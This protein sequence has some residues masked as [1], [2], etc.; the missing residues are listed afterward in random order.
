M[1]PPPPPPR[2]TGLHPA[3]PEPLCPGETVKFEASTSPTDATVTW[4]IAVNGE[5]PQIIQGDENTLRISGFSGQTI[6]VTASIPNSNSLSATARWKDAELKLDVPPGPNNGRY[7]ITDEPRMPV[8]TATAVGGG[9][10]EWEVT[11]AFTASDCPPFGPHDLRTLFRASRT[12]GNQV[13]TDFFG[14]V[15]RGGGISFHAKGVVNGCPVSAFGGAGL[16]GTNPQRTAIQKAIEDAGIDPKELAHTLGRIACKESGQRQFDAPP[17]GGTGYCPLFGPGGTVGIMQLPKPTDDEIW[18]WTANLATGIDKFKKSIKN[19]QAYL[20]ALHRSEKFGRL[21]KNFNEKRQQQGL[22]PIDIKCEFNLEQLEK[23]VIRGYYDGWVGADGFGLKLHEYKV[24][25][26]LIDGKEVLV[27]T[28][29]NEQTLQGKVVWQRVPVADRPAGSRQDYVEEVLAF[30]FDCTANTAQCNLTGIT[31]SAATLFIDKPDGFTKSTEF[32]AEGTGLA[33]VR[34]RAPGGTPATGT[35]PTFTTKWRKFGQKTVKATCGG[36]TKTATVSV[37]QVEIQINETSSTKDD[38]VQLKSEHPPHSFKVPC[39]ARLRGATDPLDIVLTSHNDRLGFVVGLGDPTPTKALRLPKTGD[40]KFEITGE[41]AS[42]VI[43]D[44]KIQVKLGTAT[45][46]IV[47]EQNVTVFSFDEAKIELTRG[48][49]YIFASG[50]FIPNGIA[51]S[52]K[53]KARL[54]PE[55]LDCNA[56]QIKKL[57]VAIMQ[58]ESALSVRIELGSPKFV[59]KPHVHVPQQEIEVAK[60]VLINVFFKTLPPINDANKGA[61]PPLYASDGAA[62]KR[63]TGCRGAGF[64]ASN[65]SP[66]VETSPYA[67]PLSLPGVGEV[68]WIVWPVVNSVI[69]DSRFLTFCVVIDMGTTPK[70]ICALREATWK[71]QIDSRKQNQHADVNDDGVASKDPSMPPPV[72]N[73]S[74][75]QSP[76]EH[77][78]FLLNIP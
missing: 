43:G 24:A 19:V 56:P 64:A 20:T 49:D 77:G 26:D 74:H 45:G 66:S 78:K 11:V 16:V 33:D 23:D 59:R 7:V 39:N 3:S 44:A 71:L 41:K 63:P 48:A 36:K 55:G 14:N 13:S 28:D 60:T 58:E 38:V 72:A 17:N 27:V 8:V 62:L 30:N 4:K 29:V 9:V 76:S 37:L 61:I 32:T 21:L 10:S 31:P 75:E 57:R 65:D 35:G 69:R 42:S 67:K 51:V 54:R 68:G 70:R 6:V 52:F 25:V 73:E 53:A 50:L 12:G 1:P 40:L 22:H 34:W 18:N 47:A 15:V 46:P 5:D 2:V